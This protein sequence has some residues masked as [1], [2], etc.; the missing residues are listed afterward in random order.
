M[1]RITRGST[2]VI[3]ATGSGK[4]ATKD[5]CDRYDTDPVPFQT[6]GEVKFNSKVYRAKSVRKALSLA[7][8]H[9]CC[10][11]EAEFVGEYFGDVE[12]FRPKSAVVN[13]QTK[14]L[15]YPGYYWLATI[16]RI[17]CSA[18]PK[19]IRRSKRTTFHS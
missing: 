5:L 12:H 14:A 4:R 8:H 15:E 9:K 2:P 13:E 3:L 1:I 6:P 11:T 17:F 19:S 16:G 7:Q 10:F 18:N